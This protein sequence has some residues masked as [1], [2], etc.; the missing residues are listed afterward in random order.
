MLLVIFGAGAS[1]DSAT[2]A[3]GKE[4]THRPPL[5]KD[6]VSRQF[7]DIAAQIP[8]SRPVIDRLRERMATAEPE[9]LE[10]ALATLAAESG[11][12]AERRQQLIAFRFFLHRVIEETVGTWMELTAGFTHYL[13]LMNAL[14][15]WQHT[16]GTPIR[17][18]TFN[19]DV[20]LEAAVTDVLHWDFGQL[21]RYIERNDVRV[22]KLHGSTTWS[23]L[24][25]TLAHVG[26]SSIAAA[27]ELA[28]GNGASGGEIM[29]IRP[30]QTVELALSSA[31]LDNDREV[32]IPALAVPTTDKTDFECPDEHRRALLQDLPKVTHLLIIGWRAAEPHAVELL[33]P[34]DPKEGLM[35]GYVLGIV[36]RGEEGIGQ[37]RRNLGIA[38]ERGKL[39]LHEPRGFSTF[40]MRM[41]E[42]LDAFLQ[43]N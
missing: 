18:V 32:T 3:R 1:F 37:V 27:M 14:F 9:P 42:H 34:E 23:R 11:N 41:S 16:T 40:V 19:Y 13:R 22:F 29:P 17:L 39:R 38:G 43:P 30:Q 8:S 5:A 10:A 21:P 28:R 4:D 24:L 26:A 31:A 7:D 36:D 12:S 2:Y 20:M 33:A 6:L 25:P 15:D 35:P